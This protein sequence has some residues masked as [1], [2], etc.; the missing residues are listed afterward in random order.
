M[1]SLSLSLSLPLSLPVSVRVIDMYASRVCWPA[2]LSPSCSVSPCCYSPPC[3][4]LVPDKEDKRAR[5]REYTD[6]IFSL[7]LTRTCFQNTRPSTRISFLYSL[8]CLFLL[9]LLLCAAFH[10]G[11]F[12]VT[13]PPRTYT[14]RE[15]KLALLRIRAPSGVRSQLDDDDDDVKICIGVQRRAIAERRTQARHQ[16]IA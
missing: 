5:N 14:H 16:T 6:G 11:N 9:L 10:L 8:S 1:V 12:E 4:G 7:S 2:T 15:S 3:P 13:P